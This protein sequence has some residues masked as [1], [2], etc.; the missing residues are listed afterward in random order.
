M[1]DLIAKQS[2]ISDVI[3]KIKSAEDA[4]SKKTAVVDTESAKTLISKHESA[5]TESEFKL[6]NKFNR[7]IGRRLKDDY[8]RHRLSLAKQTIID[9]F[10]NLVNDLQVTVGVTC[11]KSDIEKYVTDTLESYLLER[12]VSRE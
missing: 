3:E 4:T 7:V 12:R 1:A 9:N 11:T 2:S 6:A 10:S 5:L 8:K